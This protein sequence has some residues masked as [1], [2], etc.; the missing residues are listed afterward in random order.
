MLP[1]QVVG[2]YSSDADEENSTPGAC[3]LAY[4]VAADAWTAGPC[5]R[6]PRADACAAVVAG[7]LY[8]AGQRPLLVVYH[9]IEL[10]L[11]VF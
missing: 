9:L 3:L 4:S 5:M 7:K 2:G 10:D 6:S 8:V 11:F 1:L